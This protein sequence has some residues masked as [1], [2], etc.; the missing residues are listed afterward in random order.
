MP[1]TADEISD[2]L[3]LEEIDLNLF[4]GR[5]PDTKLQRVFGG[6]VAAQA[7]VAASR[8]T[9]SDYLIHSL[10]SYFLR[11]GDTS[12]PIVY[13]VE[14]IREGRS[15]AT[16]RVVA[17][18][19]G[20]GIYFMTADFQRPEEG[21]DHQDPMPDVSPPAEGTDV[22]DFFRGRSNRDP[23]RGNGSGPPS[24]CAT[25]RRSRMAADA[26]PAHTQLWIRINGD[27]PDDQI[28][29]NAAFTYASDLTL[30][31]ATLG[32]HG[33]R[34]GSPKIQP[35]SLDHTIWF[36][37]P[38]RADEW[39]LYDQYS[40]SASGGRGLA[41][42]RVFSHDGRLVASVAQEG[43]IR[44]RS[45]FRIERESGSRSAGRR[46]TQQVQR[47]RLRILQRE[48]VVRADPPYPERHGARQEDR[49]LEGHVDGDRVRQPVLQC[50]D[51]AGDTPHPVR[52]L[53][54]EP[55]RPRGHRV[56]MDRVP[57]ARHRGVPTTEIR[58]EPP[59]D[60]ASGHG[61]ER[62]ARVPRP[63]RPCRSGGSSTCSARPTRRSR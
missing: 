54:L 55:E 18:Q 40:P 62:A 42:A 38:F 9:P 53:A 3:D 10:H 21:F 26:L 6:Q 30:L 45:A 8:T 22:A 43:L 58:R 4:R 5:Q 23:S 51:A 28:T 46:P 48:L 7:L 17:R 11:P 35:A 44:V 49:L 59:R 27:M 14:A 52:Y 47:A 2:L 61:R 16:R 41:L 50:G 20:R 33:V 19:H 60:P 57:V 12:V 29:Q 1:R 34:I 31:G 24:M 15:F 63:D 25:S 56:E 39:W 37:R 13:D 36:H 32:P